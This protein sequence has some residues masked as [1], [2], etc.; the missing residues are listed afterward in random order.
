[1]LSHIFVFLKVAKDVSVAKDLGCEGV[2]FGVLKSDGNVDI[3]R[4]KILKDAAE[5]LETTFHRAIDMSIDAEKALEELS[6]IGIDRVLTSGQ[7]SSVLEGMDLI[8]KLVAR[9]KELK[10]KICCGGGITERNARKIV[11]ESGAQ[12]FHTSGRVSRQS[13]MEHRNERVFMGG[14]FRPPEFTL[15]VV[16]SKRVAK[17]REV[18][19]SN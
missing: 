17:F 5:P 3:E 4:T 10:I 15:S 9:S 14:T 6:S 11:H 19:A 16:D 1:M 8:K 13:E 7:E 2:V 18:T 12:E